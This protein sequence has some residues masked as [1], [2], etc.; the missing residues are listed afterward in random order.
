M[1]QT[2]LPRHFALC[3][4]PK[5]GKSLVQ[6]ILWKKFGIRPIDDGEPLREFGITHLGLTTEQVYTQAGKLEN[7]TINGNTWPVRKILGELGNAFEGMFGKNIMPWMAVNKLRNDLG[8]FSYGSVRRDQGA[9]YKQRGG[10]VIEIINPLAGPSTYEFDQYD[11]GIVDYRINN[12]ALARGMTQT[13]A[14]ADLEMKVVSLVEGLA[15][16]RRAA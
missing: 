15:M 14:L 16:I 7:A 9:F 13:E 2:K 6:E 5:S 12:D 10:V 11:R 1:T 4:N 3:G 8:S